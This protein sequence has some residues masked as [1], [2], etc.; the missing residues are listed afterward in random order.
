MRIIFRVFSELK[1]SPFAD[2]SSEIKT[3]AC[4]SSINWRKQ[5]SVIPA[6]GASQN[7]FLARAINP[8]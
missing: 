7:G 2:T 4:I 5:T 3:P 8:P 1:K 6:I